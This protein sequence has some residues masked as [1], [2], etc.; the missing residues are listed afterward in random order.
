MAAT[1]KT[2]HSGTYIIAGTTTGIILA[3]PWLHAHEWVLWLVLV[4][5]LIAL[6]INAGRQE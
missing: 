1:Q 2:N 5:L 4:G 3:Y 6:V